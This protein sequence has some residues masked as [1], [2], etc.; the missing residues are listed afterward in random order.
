MSTGAVHRL[1]KLLA[2]VKPKQYAL[3]W[4]KEVQ[5]FD[6]HAEYLAAQ[7]KGRWALRAEVRYVESVIAATLH[8]TRGW[9]PDEQ[10]AMLRQACRDFCYLKKLIEQVNDD[11]ADGIR[12]VRLEGALIARQLQQAIFRDAVSED[13]RAAMEAARAGNSGKVKGRSPAFM[14]PLVSHCLIPPAGA[15][16]RLTKR[17]KTLAAVFAFLEEVH[18]LGSALRVVLVRAYKHRAVAETVAGRYFGGHVILFPDVERSLAT[19]VTWL[20]AVAKEY[21][22]FVSYR[23][24]GYLDEFEPAKKPLDADRAQREASFEPPTALDLLEILGAAADDTTLAVTRIE[25]SVRCVTLA[26]AGELAA[27]EQVAKSLRPL[28]GGR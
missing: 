1:R 5:Q 2:F 25:E 16:T 13:I 23:I 19:T 8:Q 9:D 10:G 7:H 26:Q 11:T 27:A 17:I 12:L 4:C 22:G 15:E 21:N 20:E 6:S 18:E 3:A 28:P 14:A 24:P